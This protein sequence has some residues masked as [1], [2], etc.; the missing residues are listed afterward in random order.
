MKNMHKKNLLLLL[1]LAMLMAPTYTQPMASFIRSA[2]ARTAGF[3]RT[4]PA[5][6]LGTAGVVGTAAVASEQQAKPMPL[7]KTDLIIKN[8]A[9]IKHFHCNKRAPYWYEKEDSN[10][11]F[12]CIE[13]DSGDGVYTEKTNLG[14]TITQ[15]ARVERLK[16]LP[17]TAFQD[18]YMVILIHSRFNIKMSDNPL[19][20]DFKPLEVGQEKTVQTVDDE[21]TYCKK[22]GDG[23]FVDCKT[24]MRPGKF[25]E[26]F[27]QQFEALKQAN[28]QKQEAQK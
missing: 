17:N 16:Y 3:L 9:L 24:Q 18:Y 26:Q 8:M 7:S 20:Q 19:V 14:E 2:A 15:H 25:Y 27:R 28:I 1:S 11:G 4:K 21:A 23:C 22:S 10:S 12:H 13:N 5:R 6:I